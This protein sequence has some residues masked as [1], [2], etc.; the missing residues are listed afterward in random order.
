MSEGH[1]GQDGNSL[2]ANF[3]AFILIISAWV[4]GAVIFTSSPLSQPQP[5]ESL[6]VAM[7]APTA[8]TLPTDTSPPPTLTPT[9]EPTAVP[10]MTAPPTATATVP[11]TVAPT[12]T[13]TPLPAPTDTAAAAAAETETS[14]VV[15]SAE[16]DYD[17]EVVAQGQQ[18]YIGCSACH[19]ADALGVQ[20]LGKDL[21]NSEFVHSLSDADLLTFVKMG[22]PIW[23][24]MN[25]TGI[26]MP[27]RGGNPTLTDDD[28]LAIIAYLRSL[29]PP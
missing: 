5:P 20:G 24:E 1:Q 22:R 23:D 12:A 7:S 28:I 27:S 13:H 26:D 9:S 19:G 15:V 16:S 10:T 14:A 2:N 25:T 6:E 3:A 21:V 29:S 11:P 8:E 17:P 18:L 4:L